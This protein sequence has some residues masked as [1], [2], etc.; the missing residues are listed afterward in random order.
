M[1]ADLTLLNRVYRQSTLDRQNYVNVNGTAQDDRIEIYNGNI[2]AGAGNDYI[3]RIDPTSG[4]VR[5]NFWNAETGVRINLAEGWAEDGVGGRDTLVNIIS[6]TG[7]QSD[8]YF[9][10]DANNNFFYGQAGHDVIDGGAG[11]DIIGVASFKDN[12]GE[13]RE[14]FLSELKI[15]VSADGRTAVVL[16]PTGTGKYFR[17]DLHDVEY[18]WGLNDNNEYAQLELSSLI[19]PSTVALKTI[20]AGTEYRWNLSQ[21][22][23]TQIVLTYSFMK[24]V[25]PSMG[26]RIL[27]NPEQKVVRDALALV[28]SFTGLSFTEVLESAQSVGQIRWGVSQQSNSKGF[29]W[30]PQAK[31]LNDQAGDILMD[32]ES[33]LYLQAGGQG[34]EAL[35]HELGHALGLR[36]PV[37]SDIYDN[38]SQVAAEKFNSAQLTVMAQSKTGS[39]LSRAD[40]GILDVAALRYLYGVNKIN[41][42]DSIY[43]LIDTDG[44]SLKTIVDDEGCDVVDCSELS[45]GVSVNLV[46]GSLWDV[47]LT[48][49]GARATNNMSTSLDTVLESV[50]GTSYDDVLVGNSL[51]NQFTP[52]KGNDWIEGAEG[53]D[54]VY[55]AG[56]KSDWIVNFTNGQ[57]EL[58]S[59]RAN[60]GL[61]S[62][63][64]VERL[65]FS[66]LAIAWDIDGHAGQVAKILGAVFGPES[67]QNSQYAG[68]G[69]NLIDKGFS[70]IQLMSLA[71]DARLGA[72]ASNTQVINMLYQNL[73]KVPADAPAIGYWSSQIESGIFTQAS[74]AVMAADLEINQQNIQLTGLAVNGLEYLPA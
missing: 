35:L 36:H 58:L 14:S 46:S 48:R 34:L 24:D 3:A 65:V 64:S 38:W 70:Y 40:F 51:D 9:W 57:I 45:S 8:D 74:L 15:Q 56:S 5:V 20:A 23:G 11:I 67:V 16:D 66:D 22:I 33:M 63:D 68:I 6:A 50:K 1:M 39:D 2:F 37:N 43:K 53:L 59:C 44:Q 10:G 55:V 21:E 19:Q 26:Q 31:N 62:L 27:S 60:E 52:S 13:F 49:D 69:L 28:S 17:Y 30:L 18:I 42:N 54:T 25:V 41:T 72:G 47:G 73:L 4:D 7:S 32:E 29:S 71:I 12:T 61:K